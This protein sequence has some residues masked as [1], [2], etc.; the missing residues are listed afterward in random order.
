MRRKNSPPK[1]LPHSFGFREGTDLDKL[2]RLLDEL[3]AEHFVT[4]QQSPGER[5]ATPT[6]AS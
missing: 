4:R 1:T 5:K 3:E 2:N 6:D